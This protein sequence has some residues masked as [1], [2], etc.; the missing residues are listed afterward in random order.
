MCAA[1][2]F[3]E[4]GLHNMVWFAEAYGDETII[5]TLRGLLSRSQFPD[6]IT[7]DEPLNRDFYEKKQFV[8]KSLKLLHREKDMVIYSASCILAFSV[9]CETEINLNGPVLRHSTIN[10]KFCRRHKRLCI[11][12]KI[13]AG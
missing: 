12:R 8:E 7:I 11:T 10:F 2:S 6:L 5:H 9:N 4:K 13:V 1:G 3:S